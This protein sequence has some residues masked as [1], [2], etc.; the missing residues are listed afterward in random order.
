MGCFP[1]VSAAWKLNEES[2]I[3]NISAI[4][5]LKLR[6]GWGKTGQQE[7]P[8]L[9]GNKP[10]NYPAFASYNPSYPEASYQFGNQYYYMFRPANYNPNLTWET[11]TTKN[12]GLILDLIVTESQDQLM[13]SE[14]ILKI[15]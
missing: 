11:T 7:L 5:T 6:A 9:D 12:L 14:R 13:S 2:F 1:G 3:K 8:A 4:S 15:F 10:N